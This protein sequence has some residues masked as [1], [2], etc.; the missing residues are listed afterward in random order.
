RKGM[1]FIL[2]M[3][4]IVSTGSLYFVAE[5]QWQLAVA[6][7]GCA[8]IGFAG[9]VSLYDSLI[10]DVAPATL[11]DEV[12][13]YGF[14]L[15]YL[16]GAVLFA[17][18]VFMVASPATF[19]LASPTEAIRVSF[20]TVAIWW[21]I[22]SMPLLFWVKE[23]PH[24]GQGRL[25]A[26][27]LAELMHTV[28]A[29]VH[30]RNLL[31]FLLAYWLYIDG[32]Y[33]II[34]MAV[35]YGLSQ[36][37]SMQDLVQAILLTNF[38]GFPAALFFG[39]LGRRIGAKRGLY[40]AISVY[41]VVTTA[42]VFLRTAAEFYALAITIGLVQGGVQSLSRSLYARLIPRSQRSEYFGFYNMLGKFSAIIGPV[43]AGVV[44]L[45]AGSQRFAILSITILFAAGL[46]LLVKVRPP[47]DAAAAGSA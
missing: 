29:I 34:K 14:A 47:A 37:L 27:T 39:W 5:G 20:A 43:M 21:F 9:S 15:G 31:F 33:T 26:E 22:F 8:L 38:V 10:V 24:P 12:S 2:A 16:G 6:C 18:N 23:H 42:A 30:D 17:L 28:R 13:A 36:G 25:I 35:D 45:L 46:F 3:L 11:Y 1:L 32:V 7:F 19:G 44:A 40:I 41:F 4:G